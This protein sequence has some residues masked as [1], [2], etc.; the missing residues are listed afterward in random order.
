[1]WF[2]IVGCL[3]LFAGD[4]YGQQMCVYQ[5][6]WSEPHSVILFNNFSTEQTS[7]IEDNLI[8]VT[9]FDSAGEIK[10]KNDDTDQ[11]TPLIMMQ[12]TARGQGQIYVHRN[13]KVA[14]YGTRTKFGPS[15]ALQRFDSQVGVRD[16]GGFVQSSQP[17]GVLQLD[18]PILCQDNAPNGY[19]VFEN[20]GFDDWL[21]KIT[22]N[23]YVKQDHCQFT[24]KKYEEIGFL[25]P[26][27]IV[28]LVA[29]S[30]K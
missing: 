23:T 29:G 26:G 5:E 19:K 21:Y 10:I 9:Y 2:K 18:A 7:T 30:V 17:L 3:F 15:G 4:T 22:T 11:K 6:S 1:M 14:L 8:D 16:S 24:L 20:E 27:D 25:R 28:R 13:G 12:V